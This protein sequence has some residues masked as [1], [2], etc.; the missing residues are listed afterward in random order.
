MQKEN[1]NK[2]LSLF[3]YYP[4][5]SFSHVFYASAHVKRILMLFPDLALQYMLSAALMIN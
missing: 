2:D 1:K 4:I 3:T 5:W